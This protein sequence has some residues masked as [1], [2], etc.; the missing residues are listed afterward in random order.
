MGQQTEEAEP[1]GE[2][3]ALI[4]KR[5]WAPLIGAALTFLAGCLALKN[6]FTG[7]TGESFGSTNAFYINSVCGIIF[8]LFGIVSI[9]GAYCAVKGKYFMIAILGAI[10]GMVSDG[11][12][13]FLSGL[14][15]L[16]LFAISNEDF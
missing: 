4:R 7:V 9:I 10:L 15:A 16:I 2:L 1:E 3:D 8:I 14:A 11:A 12:I 13:G 6:G 5:G